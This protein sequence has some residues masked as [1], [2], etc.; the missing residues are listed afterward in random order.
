[1]RQHR[2]LSRMDLRRS[3]VRAFFT[4][5]A[6][7]LGTI[8]PD[9]SAARASNAPVVQSHSLST[10]A[11]PAFWNLA[12][13]A[14][15]NARAPRTAHFPHAWITARLAR[16]D[17]TSSTSRLDVET[18]GLRPRDARAFT[19]DATAPPSIVGL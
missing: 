18:T 3:P 5:L 7:V 11:I 19:Y 2:Y 16:L 9:R 10:A 15:P 12:T 6:F 17:A 14:G 1:M 4:V 13:N 8:A